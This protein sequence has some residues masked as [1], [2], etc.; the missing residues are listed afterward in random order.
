MRKSSQNFNLIEILISMIVIVFAMFVI[1]SF[2]PLAQGQQAA[3]SNQTH[4]ANF[5]QNMMAYIK[6]EAQDSLAGEEAQYDLINSISSSKSLLETKRSS[7]DT[8]TPAQENGS[9]KIYSHKTSSSIFLI[10]SMSTVNAREVKEAEIEVRL[11]KSPS[12]FHYSQQEAFVASSPSVNNATNT[13]NYSSITLDNIYISSGN[14]V[15]PDSIN[16]ALR[17][18]TTRIVLEF[19]WPLN[20]KYENRQKKTLFFDQQILTKN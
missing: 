11:W 14:A 19:S 2:L 5:A 3:A 16:E 12:V 8:S 6:T 13:Q 18:R 7:F 17:T 10:R 20:S 15:D 4:L 1:I 9:T